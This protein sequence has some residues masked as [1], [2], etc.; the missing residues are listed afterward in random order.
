MTLDDARQ[1]LLRIRERTGHYPMLY[2]NDDVIRHISE[3]FGKD[4]V[5]RQ[6]GLWYARFLPNVSD[7]PKGTWDTYTLWQFK[8]E[9]N[10]KP[11]E[12]SLC[13]YLVPG[14]KTDMDVNVFNGTIEELKTRWPF[15]YQR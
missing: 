5:F 14:T 15:R 6:T 1:F 9:L 4:D 10:C 11:T 7:F 13:P 8:S 2:G 12:T 3:R